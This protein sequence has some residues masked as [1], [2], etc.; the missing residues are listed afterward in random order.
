MGETMRRHT[1]TGGV[2]RAIRGLLFG[3]ATG[4]VLVAGSMPSQAAEIQG[5]F[6]LPIRCEAGTI[7]VIQQFPDLDPGPGIRDPWCGTATYDGHDGTDFRVL[8]MTDMKAGVPVVAMSDGRVRGGRDG[9]M[10]TLVRTDADRARVADRECGNGVAIDHGEGVESQYCHLRTGS[11]KVKPGD[12]VRKGDPLGLVGASGMAA[13]PHVHAVVRVNGEAVDLATGLKAGEACLV[14]GLQSL[15]NTLLDASA[16]A[17]LPE[18]GQPTFLAAGFAAAPV[19]DRSLVDEGLPAPPDSRSEAFVG[20]GWVINLAKGDRVKVVVST[21]AG[22]V[23]AETTSEPMDRSKAVYTAYAGR[24]ISPP[25][26]LYRVRAEVLRGSGRAAS[27][28]VAI[29]IR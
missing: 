25:P 13:F 15:E 8:T 6:G 24:K 19:D 26:G 11:V 12:I 27:R 14:S 2:V 10:D 3:V 18:P 23:F 20:Y 29:T 21:D 5:R 16:R 22:Q 7:C 17:A 9:M 1:P 28:E 4:L